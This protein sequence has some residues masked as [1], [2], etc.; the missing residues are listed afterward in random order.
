MP[1]PGEVAYKAHHA[2]MEKKIHYF[3][4]TEGRGNILKTKVCKCSNLE[5]SSMNHLLNYLSLYFFIQLQM[6]TF[7]ELKAPGIG[8]FLHH[9]EMFVLLDSDLG[10]N[11]VIQVYSCISGEETGMGQK[12]INCVVSEIGGEM[13]N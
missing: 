13:V 6:V 12:G 8:L 10:F 11:V 4:L 1:F 2:C 3:P 5:D 9:I 7:Q